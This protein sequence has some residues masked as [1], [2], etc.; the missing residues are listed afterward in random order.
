MAGNVRKT[1]DIDSTKQASV[2][3]PIPLLEWRNRLSFVSLRSNSNRK[4]S[5]EGLRAFD[6]TFGLTVNVLSTLSNDGVDLA[7]DVDPSIVEQRRDVLLNEKLQV[8]YLT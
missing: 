5:A 4:R 7:H 2:K 6:L 1:P 8:L 3:R